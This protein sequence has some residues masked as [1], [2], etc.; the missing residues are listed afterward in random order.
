MGRVADCRAHAAESLAF[1][2]RHGIVIGRVWTLLALGELDLGAGRAEPAVENFENARAELSAAGI[3]DMDLD[4]RVDLV[5]A[6]VRLG[7]DDEARQLAHDYHRLS[8]LKGQPWALARAERVLA[9]TAPDGEVDAHFEAAA[10]LHAA[11][12]DVFETARTALLHG[13]SLRRRRRRRQARTHLRAA[14][15]AFEQLGAEQRAEQAAQEL[16][17]TGETVQRRGASLLLTLTPQ[18]RQIAELLAEGRTTR[19]AAAALFLSPKTVEYHLR[20]VYDKLGVN[21]RDALAQ[22]IGAADSAS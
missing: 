19:Q 15:A 2:E 9:L 1:C 21:S 12:P 11:T 7:R 20:H 18:E 4:P 5:E 3:Q 22:V 10:R 8:A 16:A 6:L 17:A 13:M 14:L